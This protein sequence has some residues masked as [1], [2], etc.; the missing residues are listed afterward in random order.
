MLI[1]PKGKSRIVLIAISTFLLFFGA[2]F[3]VM[4]DMKNAPDIQTG[5]EEIPVNPTGLLRI[6]DTRSI[7]V[8]LAMTE[9]AWK[10]GL[11]YRE[12]MD[13]D[14]G[15]LFVSH[16]D[17]KSLTF[18]MYEMHFPL[19]MIFLDG[20]TVVDVVKDIPYPESA[21][22]YPATITSKEPANQVLE[23]NAGKADEWGI[24][25]GD[26]LVLVGG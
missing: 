13:A 25:V 1:H 5:G 26:R 4:K 2:F 15:M 16:D 20:E 12:S 24:E 11:S 19:D 18:W 17:P 10:T 21:F 14:R 6:D 3:L 23:I 9:D 7:P 8:E 22:A